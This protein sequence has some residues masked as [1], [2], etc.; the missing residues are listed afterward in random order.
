[1][2]FDE[3]ELEAAAEAMEPS[4]ASGMGD[5]QYIPIERLKPNPRNP[6]KDLGDLTE[7]A[8]SIRAK[9]VLQNL[10]VV[11]QWNE[12]EK[13]FTDYR[14]VIGHRRHGAARLAGLALLPCAIACMTPQEEFETMMVENIQ[15]CA[16]T[17]IEEAEGFQMM[18]DMGDTMETVAKKTGVSEST[19]RRRRALL[20]LPRDKFLESQQRGGR[21]ED[22]LR[23][24]QIRDEA[25]RN[26]VL[27]TVGTPNFDNRLRDALDEQS[28]LDALEQLKRQLHE[29]DWCRPWAGED[30]YANN[31]WSWWKGFDKWTRKQI[32]TP[33]DTDVAEY[34]FREY[35]REVRI[36]RKGPKAEKKK[37]AATIRLEKLERDLGKVRKELDRLAKSHM[38]RRI[39]FIKNFGGFATAEHDIMEMAARVLAKS[40]TP[41]YPNMK[42]LKAL[43]GLEG[44]RDGCSEELEK[45]GWNHLLFHQSAKGLLYAVYCRLEIESREFYTRSYDSKLGFSV[46]MYYDDKLLRQLL[47][48]LETLGYELS[49]EERQMTEGKHPLFDEIRK[50]IKDYNREKGKK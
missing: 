5:I 42:L 13:A 38:E 9:G 19:I 26:K 2:S 22:Y 43:T 27:D 20:Q 47:G 48:Y 15:R 10:T 41:G 49:D 35:D 4:T 3:L 25:A 21:M 39:A 46:P 6:R 17:P 11:P 8:D 30:V 37:D 14:I 12:D 29:A 32:K 16:L 36:Y 50:L 1:M 44:V 31:D 34:M 45:E 18:L 33:T 7:L 28:F 24:S 23:L 40:N